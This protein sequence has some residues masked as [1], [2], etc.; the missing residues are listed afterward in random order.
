M[1][2]IADL[3][4][5]IAKSE[6][7]RLV[8]CK[9]VSI[10][11]AKYLADVAPIDGGPVIHDVRLVADGKPS[12]V[13]IPS[14]DSPV[15]VGWISAAAAVVVCFG[16]SS[17]IEAQVKTSRLEITEAGTIIE[18]GTVNLAAELKGITDQLDELCQKL[19]TLQ[20]I[21]PVGPG[22]I[23]PAIATEIVVIQTT[24]KQHA[25]AIQTVLK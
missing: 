17:K 21:T 19:V 14:V 8:P 24:L 22:V 2:Q 23:Q 5:K 16:E 11:T 10:D 15:I 7:G 3:L 13:A 20:T 12:L 4:R 18:K 6:G 25:N 9:V 1:S